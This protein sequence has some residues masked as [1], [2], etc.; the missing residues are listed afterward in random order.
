MSNVCTLSRKRQKT[1]FG[2]PVTQLSICEA[3]QI[4]SLLVDCGYNINVVGV[5]KTI[6]KWVSG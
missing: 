1:I 6:I 3:L 4:Q 2:T 5:A